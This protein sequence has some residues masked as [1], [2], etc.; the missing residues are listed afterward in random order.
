[1]FLSILT[2]F[3]YASPQDRPN[4]LFCIADDAGQEFLSMN[5]CT[6]V[7]TPNIDA[8]AKNGINFKRAYTPSPKCAPSRAI[9]LTGRNPW[10]LDAAVNHWCHFPDRFKTFGESLG[11][12]GYEVAHGGKTWG[13]GTYKEGREMVGKS[14]ESQRYKEKL[15]KGISKDHYANNFAQFMEERDPKKPFFYWFGC[16][17]PHRTYEYGS[18]LK[19]GKK[20]SDIE[21][22]PAYWP[23][24]EEVRTDML[25][26]AVEVEHFDHHVGLMVEQ[27]KKSGHLE[28]T[29]IIVTSDNGMPFPREKGHPYENSAHM[30]LV[31]MWPKGIAGAGRVSQELV[32]FIDIAP[33]LLDMAQV[34]NDKHGMETIT[35]KSLLPIFKNEL[36]TPF[37]EQL[38]MGRERNDTGRP[39]NQ[40]Y[41]VRVLLK[42]D[43]FYVHNF[44]SDRWPCSN[45]ETGFRDT[46]AS[47]TMDAVLMSGP[48]SSY[49]EWCVGKRPEQEMYN[50]KKDPDCLV[51]LASQPE[52]QPQLEAMKKS[53]FEAL[54]LEGDLWMSGRGEEYEKHPY[55]KPGYQNFY[56]DVV[57]GKMPSGRP[58]FYEMNLD[59]PQQ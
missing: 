46:G 54:T 29:L 24:T 44:K 51:N 50:I 33:T 35:G 17:E 10:Q 36:N 59:L 3:T 31:M 52:Y 21:R 25:D 11:E 43:L 4:I 8:I 47:K 34:P 20:C 14:Y 37:R 6:W 49:W 16:H 42:G 55:V 45:P 23:D 7:K 12:H 2:T 58:K 41:P 9:L 1:M 5:G 53:L 19:S 30:P 15:A 39:H 13:P 27:L 22:I 48:E 56:E 26:Y 18:G 28:N 38:L 40:G 57:S 32:S